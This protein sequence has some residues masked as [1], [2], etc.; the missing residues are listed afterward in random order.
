MCEHR[1]EAHVQADTTLVRLNQVAGG[2]DKKD[3]RW[4]LRV[5]KIADLEDAAFVAERKAL[6]S[7][8]CHKAIEKRI[9]ELD[10]D[11]ICR[12]AICFHETI[13]S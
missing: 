13:I 4:D 2:D 6:Q 11:S 10:E 9:G 8:C 12:P 5:A 7:K 3:D 1:G